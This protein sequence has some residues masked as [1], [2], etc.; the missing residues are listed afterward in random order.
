MRK[1]SLKMEPALPRAEM[2]LLAIVKEQGD[3][4]PVRKGLL[5]SILDNLPFNILVF[6]E[7]GF[8]AY[9]NLNFCNLVGYEREEILGLHIS[10]YAEI[11]VPTMPYDFSRLP[12]I[13]QGEI[14]AGYHYNLTHLDGTNIPVEFNSYPLRT[15][16]EAKPIGCL[17]VINPT[18]A[19]VNREK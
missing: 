6:D 17:V 18:T 8:I 12:R 19:N 13:L 2:E 9:A 10:E 7:N 15:E 1:F 11:L 16:P 5:Q 4:T 3:K 14:I